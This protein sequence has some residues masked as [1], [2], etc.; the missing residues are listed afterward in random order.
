MA[1]DGYALPDDPR[2]GRTLPVVHPMFPLLAMMLGGAGVAWV[3]FAFNAFAMGSPKRKR[4]L[5]AVIGAFVGTLVAL[6]GVIVVADALALPDGSL[7]YLVLVVTVWKLG[8]S[9]ALF[10]AQAAPFALYQWYGGQVRNGV[11]GL[12]GL[13]FLARSFEDEL[14]G[15]VKVVVG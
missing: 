12:V 3:W 8:V 4:D 14:P 6:V 15:L 9:Y 1:R 11:L 13:A 7:P 10:N 2:P 5:A